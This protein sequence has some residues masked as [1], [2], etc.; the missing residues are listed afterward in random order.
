MI[1]RNNRYEGFS[2]NESITTGKVSDF[3]DRLSF[4]IKKICLW[5]LIM[6]VSIAES[7]LQNSDT[8]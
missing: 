7:C 4:C 6:Q 1:D 2:T 5:F 8:Y 3:L